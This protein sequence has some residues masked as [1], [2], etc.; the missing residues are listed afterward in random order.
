VGQKKVGFGPLSDHSG[1]ETHPGQDR[2][3]GGGLALL[4]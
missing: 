3:G 4:D 2:L 1:G